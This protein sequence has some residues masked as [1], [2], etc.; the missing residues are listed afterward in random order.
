MAFF[1]RMNG[2]IRSF[3]RGAAEEPAAQKA[4]TSSLGSNQSEAAS[5]GTKQR[6][7]D[8]LG[9]SGARDSAVRNRLLGQ[10][11]AGIEAGN[12]PASPVKST[13]SGRAAG[14]SNDSVGAIFHSLVLAQ[15]ALGAEAL[16]LRVEELGNRSDPA[17]R[18]RLAANRE[19]Q[20]RNLAV[21][22]GLILFGQQKIAQL[23]TL[24]ASGCPLSIQQD[25]EL[26]NHRLLDIEMRL[27]RRTPY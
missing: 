4:D 25:A 27:M 13:E 12:R 3:F 1:V 5:S 2:Q 23:T 10:T 17:K 18:A 6:G 19:Q 24:Q 9:G 22:D 16:S 15:N 7:S 21:L 26:T 14:K 11:H 20:A 8:A